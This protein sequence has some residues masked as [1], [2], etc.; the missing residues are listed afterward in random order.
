MARIAAVRRV[1]LGRFVS[2]RIPLLIM[3]SFLLEVREENVP[4]YVA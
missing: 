4:R 1:R 3:A 2:V